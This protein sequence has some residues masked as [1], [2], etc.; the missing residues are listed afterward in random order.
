[1]EADPATMTNVATAQL[2]ELAGYWTDGA[3]VSGQINL[4]ELRAVILAIRANHHMLAGREVQ[5][6]TDNRSV[7][8]VCNS[9]RSRA[10]T[11]MIEYRELYQLLWKHQISLKAAWIDTVSNE[12]ADTL[13]RARDPTEYRWAPELVQL[14]RTQWDLV[15]N[16]DCFAAPWCKQ[17]G[18]TWDSRWA[19][20]EAQHIDTMLTSWTR[21]Q[22]WWTPPWNFLPETLAKIATD[23][24]RGVLLTPDWPSADGYRRVEL[25]SSGKIGVPSAH[26]H[27][28]PVTTNLALPEPS[29]NKRWG[30]VLWLLAG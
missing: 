5:L 10:P 7:M 16:H 20:D 8:A 3:H 14:A 29:K 13:S 28:L 4:L 22:C 17:P 2:D 25:L 19:S 26:L 6:W 9:H 30:C 24:A 12:R 1:V 27:V 11:L 23:Q 15:L 21:K 18:M